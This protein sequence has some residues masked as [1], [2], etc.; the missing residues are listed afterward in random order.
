[1][2]GPVK[3]IGVIRNEYD[4]FVKKDGQIVLTV[5]K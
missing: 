4:E 5:K 2:R 1:M 3:T